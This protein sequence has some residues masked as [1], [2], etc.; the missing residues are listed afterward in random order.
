MTEGTFNGALLPAAERV[1]DVHIVEPIAIRCTL[2]PSRKA[3]RGGDL[4]DI[5]LP[6]LALFQQPCERC[7]T[8]LSNENGLFIAGLLALKGPHSTVRMS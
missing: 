6:L 7:E 2:C 3:R 1:I 5:I 8:W 4:G